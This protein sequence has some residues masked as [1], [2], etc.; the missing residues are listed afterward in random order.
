MYRQ[1]NCHDWKEIGVKYF[2]GGIREDGKDFNFKEANRDEWSVY[3]H[4]PARY[5]SI[6]LDL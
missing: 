6:Q 3:L 2:D 5:V 1:F 4:D